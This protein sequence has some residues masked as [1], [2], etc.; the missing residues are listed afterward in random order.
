MSI[1]AI[2]ISL[3][4]F[5]YVSS[6]L[7]K[8][9]GKSKQKGSKNKGKNKNKNKS[10]KGKK[11]DKSSPKEQYHSSEKCLGYEDDLEGCLSL[12]K[13]LFLKF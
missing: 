11:K 1:K 2:F 12:S 9:E 7:A 5:Y 13:L 3:L 8:K 4:I 10:G 6:T